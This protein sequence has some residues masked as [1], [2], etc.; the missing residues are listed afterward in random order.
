[1]AL[2]GCNID[3]TVPL[4]TGVWVSKDGGVWDRGLPV[5]RPGVVMDGRARHTAGAM[6][7][8]LTGIIIID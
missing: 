3:Q 4:I 6:D 5:F 7:H 2:L 8:V 1:M